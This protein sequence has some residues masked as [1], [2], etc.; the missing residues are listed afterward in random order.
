[1]LTRAE[2]SVCL[3]AGS[4]SDR[5]VTLALTEAHTNVI[6]L[7]DALMAEDSPQG[8]PLSSRKVEYAME[9]G[10]LRPC[11][12]RHHQPR[13]VA[14]TSISHSHSHQHST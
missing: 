14:C 4:L 8:K 7:D 5:A 9:R 11:P 12:R 10:L 1:M 13:E 6:T 3:P 2:P